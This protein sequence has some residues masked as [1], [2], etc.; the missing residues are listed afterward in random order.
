MDS[1]ELEKLDKLR[2]YDLWARTVLLVVWA[3]LAIW[4]H[5]SGGTTKW[6]FFL[7]TSFIIIHTTSSKILYSQ[8]NLD[9]RIKRALDNELYK[10]YQ[11]KSYVW[12]FWGAMFALVVMMLWEPTDTRLSYMII[13]FTGVLTMMIAKLIFF[14][15]SHE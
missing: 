14:A 5:I 3:G 13:L 7:L 8:I 11:Y 2:Y 9:T 12:G 6:T 4:W 15:K 1:K 10:M